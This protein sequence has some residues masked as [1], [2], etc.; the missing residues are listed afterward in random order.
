MPHVR[1]LAILAAVPAFVI[2]SVTAPLAAA[3]APPVAPSVDR[4]VA[5]EVS[6]GDWTG[7][8]SF[9]LSTTGPEGARV[10]RPAPMSLHLERQVCDLAGCVTTV[11]ATD[12]SRPVPSAARIASS[13][14]SAALG[15]VLVG[16]TVTRVVAG[17]AV[18]ATP[19]ALPVQVAVRKSG[20]VVRRTALVQSG[21]VEQMTIT[22]IAP[23]RASITLADDTLVAT[24]LA[25]KTR[26][27]AG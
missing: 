9:G 7:S 26:I 2:P 24:G 14:S 4:Q 23:V 17:R 3:A 11:I 25:Q 13:L 1:S 15:P 21:D 22:W 8:L 6:E 20:V 19:M 5:L 18:A 10:V 12:P 16:V 27:V